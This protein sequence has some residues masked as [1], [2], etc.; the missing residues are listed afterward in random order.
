MG[1]LQDSL[2]VVKLAAKFANPEL[3]ERVTA[4]NEQVLELSTKSVEFQQQVFRLERE[5]RSANEKLK[6]IGD[7]ER[8]GGFIYLKT[9]PEP[10]CSRCF[11]VDRVLVHVIETRDTKLGIHPSC[12]QCKT[13]F[14][15]YP[16]G[17]RGRS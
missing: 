17:L 3:I 6:L 5:L 14:G 4:L 9:E 10:C 15:A 13:A 12:P 16:Q 8:R 2:E 11:D 1:I 7:V